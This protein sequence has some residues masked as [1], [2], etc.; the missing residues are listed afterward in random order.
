MLKELL[1]EMIKIEDVLMVVKSNGATMEMKS[2]SLSIRQKE[3]WITIGENDGPCHMH[4]NVTMIKNAEF[5]LEEKPERI[6]YS[7]RFFDHDGERT[8]A[9][10]FTKMYDEN[11]IIKSERKKLYDNLE[12]KYGKKIQF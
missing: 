12:K 4:V 10:F 11:K 3:Q 5:I 8:L 6:S 1:E 7:V 9:C 2:N